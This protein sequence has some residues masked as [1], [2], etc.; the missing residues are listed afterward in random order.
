M[1]IVEEAMCLE[2]IVPWSGSR[3][4]V[5]GCLQRVLVHSSP[6]RGAPPSN[7]HHAPRTLFRDLFLL[8]LPRLIYGVSAPV[9]F[10]F[11]CARF[12]CVF[13]LRCFLFNFI[14]PVFSFFSFL[15]FKF[16]DS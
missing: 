12:L 8:G 2:V 15:I 10:S 11:I 9:A 7:P 1:G 14:Y 16:F 13:N 5:G 6:W 3:V 4:G